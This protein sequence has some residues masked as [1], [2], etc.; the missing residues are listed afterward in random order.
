VSS[1]GWVGAVNRPANRPIDRF[2][3]RPTEEMSSWRM[4]LGLLYL[5]V[6]LPIHIYGSLKYLQGRHQFP[7]MQRYPH[8]TI[9]LNWGFLIT[10]TIWIVAFLWPNTVP[11]GVVYW[12]ITIGI[13][14]GAA[15]G[16]LRLL[17]LLFQYEVTCR[18]PHNRT[19]LH[20]TA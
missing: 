8:V 6:Y 1:F 20:C 13:T 4:A 2:V 11:C 14:F 7:I 5:I 12:N 16:L 19:A 3:L 15:T 10:W 17:L 9:G 18:P